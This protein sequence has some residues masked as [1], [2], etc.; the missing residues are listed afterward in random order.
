MGFIEE[1]RKQKA[2][3][4][5]SIQDKRANREIQSSQRLAE[6]QRVEYARTEAVRQGRAFFEASYF[7]Q[8]LIELRGVASWIK[9]F[10]RDA[11]HYL[12]HAKYSSRPNLSRDSFV[13]EVLLGS[14]YKGHRDNRWGIYSRVTR[15][16]LILIES[17]RDGTIVVHGGLLSSTT[18]QRN[19]WTDNR[20]IQ[21]EALGKAFNHPMAVDHIVPVSSPPMQG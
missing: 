19:T 13:E 21:E 16:K 5:K 7:P 4:E 20:R 8:L 9:V 14:S 12:D 11:E 3:R 15:E 2:Y 6:Q 10:P 17:R 18:M 1:L